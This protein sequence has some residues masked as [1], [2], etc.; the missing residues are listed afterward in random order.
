MSDD[1]SRNAVVVY[2]SHWDNTAS[3]A[4]AIG[5]G[6][7]PATQVLATDQVSHGELASADLLVVGAPVIALG[8]PSPRVEE[9]LA[10]SAGDA[11]R[12]PDQAHPPI[13]WWLD[14]LPGGATFAAAFET[15]LAESP[16]SAVEAI[17]RALGA[18]GYRLL[19]PAERFVVIG[20]YGP[21]EQGELDR[22]QL[23]GSKLRTLVEVV[24]A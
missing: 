5:A 15:R 11:P 18:R 21:L 20:P 17:E 16:G 13:F 12:P 1:H 24:K 2:E 22:A 8:L 9:E 6:L 23:W 19:A 10:K 14:N 7:G 3:I 4:R